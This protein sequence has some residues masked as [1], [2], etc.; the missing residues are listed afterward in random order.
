M[1][2]HRRKRGREGGGREKEREERR[3]ERG[4]E[5]RKEGRKGEREK[6]RKEV[7]KEGKKLPRVK[8][9][10]EMVLSQL[11]QG[12]SVILSTFLIVLLITLAKELGTCKQLTLIS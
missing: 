6:G 11:S 1:V 4:R 5:A 12:P 2:E 10:H 3:K 7:R 8:I 9:P